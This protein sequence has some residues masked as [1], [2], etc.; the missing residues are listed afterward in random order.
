MSE[1]LITLGLNSS[2]HVEGAEHSSKL[3]LVVLALQNGISAGK[4]IGDS[5]DIFCRVHTSSPHCLV[6]LG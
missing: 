3:L 2:G 4:R 5:Q 6:V 1:Y